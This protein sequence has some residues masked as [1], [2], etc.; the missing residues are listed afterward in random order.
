MY[1]DIVIEYIDAPNCFH[2]WE[3]CGENIVQSYLNTRFY[4]VSV[5]VSV[6]VCFFLIF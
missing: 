1:V 3:V 5:Y 6:S 4:D 2:F